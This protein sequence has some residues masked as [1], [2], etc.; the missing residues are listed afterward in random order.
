MRPF[1]RNT[2][3]RAYP[4]DMRPWRAGPGEPALE[5][6]RASRLRRLQR[7]SGWL[8][9]SGI[10]LAAALD[11][12][13]PTALAETLRAL[14]AWSLG[15][16]PPIACREWAWPEKFHAGDWPDGEQASVY[17]L[18]VDTGVVLGELLRRHRPG[19]DWAV[20][21]Y[22]AHGADGVAAYGRVLILDPAVPLGSLT[23]PVYDAIDEAF[24]RYQS[25]AFNDVPGRFL[26]GMRPLLWDTHRHLFVD[27]PNSH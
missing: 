22:D 14:D 24:M 27:P 2:P 17:T 18:L 9:R 7:L 8:S 13:E 26:D 16:W 21:T 20:D 5:A 6:L 1:R 10:D 23:P 12:A 19:L 25:L 11:A 4:A 15:H 3:L